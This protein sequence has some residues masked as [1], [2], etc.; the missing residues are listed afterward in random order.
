MAAKS[1]GRYLCTEPCWHNGHRYRKGEVAFF[2]P[3]EFP[4]RNIRDKL[5]DR[6]ELAH[7]E[8]LEDGKPIPEP[9]SPAVKKSKAE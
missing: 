2:G 7:F 3:D 1:K 9:P 8:L 5:G 6:K 4:V